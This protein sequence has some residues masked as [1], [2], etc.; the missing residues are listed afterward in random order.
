VP[1]LLPNGQRNVVS[2]Q[3]K[4]ACLPG[5][6]KLVA[7]RLQ[8]TFNIC[9]SCSDA[10]QELLGTLLVPEWQ[11]GSLFES[12]GVADTAII[13]AL[14]LRPEA[15]EV[16]ILIASFTDQGYVL[17]EEALLSTFDSERLTYPSERGEIHP[18]LWQRYQEW[19]TIL[20]ARY[21]NEEDYGK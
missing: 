20:R 16:S 21:P 14:T 9:L 12:P 11:Q 10:W 4:D 3:Q 2:F 5:A 17:Q 19:L 13:A 15:E 6:E 18:L 7:C 8:Q 1:R